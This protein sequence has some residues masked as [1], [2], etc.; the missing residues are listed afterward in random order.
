MVT[1]ALLASEPAGSVML[2]TAFPPAFSASAALVVSVFMVSELR[3]A[4][5]VPPEFV[6]VS[7][8]LAVVTELL[9]A[10]VV[11]VSTFGS[12][13]FEAPLPPPLLL[14]LPPDGAA[15]TLTLMLV[16]RETVFV[17]ATPAGSVTVPF[18]VKVCAAVE[19]ALYEEDA[20]SQVM[21]AWTLPL[22]VTSVTCEGSPKAAA[23]FAVPFGTPVIAAGAVMLTRVL[24]ATVAGN[25][26]VTMPV[27]AA[28]VA[29]APDTVKKSAPTPA[30]VYP[31]LGIMVIVA[32]YAVF[33]AKTAS[34]GDHDIEAVY[35][36]V[37]ARLDTGVW[38]VTGTVTPEIAAVLILS[39]L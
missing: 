38:P 27:P 36:A 34:F 37:S 6:P 3:A 16:V 33:A 35:C 13:S 32:V 17:L 4:V 18:T 15:L 19:L 22:S 39:T 8:V 2:T 11:C 26:A 29:V 28:L 14:P 12:L 31:S 25:T 20:A 5:T 10:P 24:T 9:P 23:V 21:F 1:D 7:V 30:S